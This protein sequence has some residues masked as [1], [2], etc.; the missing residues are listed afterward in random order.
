MITLIIHQRN[1]EEEIIEVL[2]KFK[3]D[4]LKLFFTVLLVQKTIRIL[5]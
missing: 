4:N 5:Y 3:N 2:N 1:S